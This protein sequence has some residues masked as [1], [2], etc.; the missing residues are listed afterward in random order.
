MNEGGPVGAIAVAKLAI[1]DPVIKARFPDLIVRHNYWNPSRAY[2][3]LGLAVVP[4]AS[5]QHI[6]GESLTLRLCSGGR[7][8]AS[9]EW[10]TEFP[11][12]TSSLQFRAA[13]IQV[14]QVFLGLLWSPRISETDRAAIG[15]NTEFAPLRRA[16]ARTT[17]DQALLA[18]LVTRDADPGVRQTAAKF[19]KDQTVLAA[20]AR[21]DKSEDVRLASLDN[22]T[23]QSVLTVVATHDPFHKVRCKAVRRVTD[24]R[25]LAQV[26]AQDKASDV[27]AAAVYKL[28]DQSALADI[29]QNDPSK[30][31]RREA[32][33]KL[34]DQRVL[35]RIA[36]KDEDIDVRHAAVIKLTDEALL[37]RI[38][39]QDKSLK[40]CKGAI[41]NITDQ[42]L[43]AEIITNVDNT[44][45]ATSAKERLNYLRS[46]QQTAPEK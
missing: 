8:V 26:A 22:L 42:S 12:Q 43:L 16:V 33:R 4:T 45:V 2:S 1:R 19:L 41:W 11:E 37:A 20:V 7:D 30:E 39:V 17:E 18:E 31:V 23:D 6:V 36:L 38:A 5:A 34:T 21:Q 44:A 3:P 15:R 29:A 40:V 10:N 14:W 9:R 13:D 35:T 28:T 32:V 46:Q 25:L 24:Q 27:R